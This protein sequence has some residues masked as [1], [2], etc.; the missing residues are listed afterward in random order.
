ML[1]A[2]SIWQNS[3]AD[4]LRRKVARRKA[5]SFSP[6]YNHY[7]EAARNRPEE[8]RKRLNSFIEKTR[9]NK[10]IM[11]YGGIEKYYG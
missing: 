9:Q 6:S 1:L 5:F 2:M 8:F 10:R 11:G 7:I 3:R 4:L